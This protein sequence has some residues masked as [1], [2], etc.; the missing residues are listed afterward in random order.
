VV[1]KQTEAILN[2]KFTR[3]PGELLRQ[4]ERAGTTDPATLPVNERFN[5]RF[6]TG[7]WVKVR[8][9]LAQMPPELARKIYDKILAD[10]TE[11]E[12]A[13]IR[14]LLARTLHATKAAS[15]EG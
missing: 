11:R 8:E 15:Q 1:I 9:E 12:L 4:L 13:T 6:L 5:L 2:Q 14:D 7:D 3:D 10:L